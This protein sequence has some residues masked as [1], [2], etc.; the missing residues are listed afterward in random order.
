[1]SFE[2]VKKVWMSGKLVEWSAATVH[3]SS[4]SLH[5]GSGV[6]EAIRCYDTG[7]AGGGP[8]LFRLDAHLDRLFRSATIHGMKVPYTPCDLDR[9]TCATVAQNGFDECYVRIL[10]YYGSGSLGVYPRNCPVEVAILAWP[11]GAYLGAGATKNGIRSTIS[12]WVKFQS[13]MMPTTA[14]ASG[15]YVNSL[16]AVRDAFDR[17]YEEAILLNAEGDIAEGSGEN[18]FVVRGGRIITNDEHS[19]ILLG[20]TR[21]AVMQIARDLG[22]EVVIGKLKLED[23]L[24]ADEA[25]FTGTAAEV[26][27]IREIDGK[28][29]GVVAAPG[30]VTQKLQ[31]EY[32]AAIQGR[33]PKYRSWLRYVR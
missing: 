21:D 9:A 27:P 7:T 28:N 22:Y 1:L 30:P 19:S 17:G 20:I 26:T 24:S 15:Q 14:K 2:G 13:R 4:H 12:S 6:F 32:L 16:L 10:C 25:F 5:L 31:E 3:I 33:S 8:A 29:I 23:L 18:I 11:M